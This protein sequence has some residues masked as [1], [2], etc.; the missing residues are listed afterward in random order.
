MD[1]SYIQEISIKQVFSKYEY[2]HWK[3]LWIA[4]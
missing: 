4:N 2:Q 1:K 3:K